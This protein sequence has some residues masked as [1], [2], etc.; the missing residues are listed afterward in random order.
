MRAIAAMAGE[1]V[2]GYKGKLPWKNRRDMRFFKQMTWGQDVIVGH[3]TFTSMGILKNRYHTVLTN[4]PT[5]ASII[6]AEGKEIVEFVTLDKID[7]S[8]YNKAWV[9]G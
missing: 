3:S 4:G 7:Q 9:I 6:D 1:R 2:I 8:A 5:P